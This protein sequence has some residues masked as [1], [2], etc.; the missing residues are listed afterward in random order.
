MIGGSENV[1]FGSSHLC[2]AYWLGRPFRAEK[3]SIYDFGGPVVR[4]PPARE[5]PW[6]EVFAALETFKL[7]SESLERSRG[8]LV[9]AHNF[10]TEVILSFPHSN[11]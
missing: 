4:R 11:T 10:F 8:E 2:A 7:K 1:C 5:R 9:C 6:S 3:N